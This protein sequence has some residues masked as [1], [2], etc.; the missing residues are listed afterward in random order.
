MK[1]LIFWYKVGCSDHI[2]FLTFLS[3]PS[4]IHLI[5]TQIDA[6]FDGLSESRLIFLGRN[7]IGG[8][9]TRILRKIGQKITMNFCISPF[10]L[11]RRQVLVTVCYRI[12]Q[13]RFRAIEWYKILIGL[14]EFSQNYKKRGKNLKNPLFSI[15]SMRASTCD[16]YFSTIA[17]TLDLY[18]L[19]LI[20]TYYDLSNQISNI[21]I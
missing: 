9:S 11:E 10:P 2:C 7:A 3:A 8:L 20:C 19:D 17:L 18:I 6:V 16:P 12:L 21:E 5:Y 15:N 13:S 4:S 14:I 1:I